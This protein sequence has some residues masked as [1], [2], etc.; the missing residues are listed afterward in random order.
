MLIN[1]GYVDL[2][3]QAAAIL[4][5]STDQRME[6]AAT[7]FYDYVLNYQPEMLSPQHESYY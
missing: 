5:E 6:R 4:Q 7:V 2:N 1:S 3:E